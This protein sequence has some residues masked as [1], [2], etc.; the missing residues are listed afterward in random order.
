[1]STSP[2]S[3]LTPDPAFSVPAASSD[4]DIVADGLRKR[5]IA[6]VVVDDGQAARAAVHNL[7]PEGAHVFNATSRTLE[8]I[9]LAK[10]I[11]EAG[12]YQATRDLVDQLNPQTQ[13][14]EYRR[15]VASPQVVVGSVHA[16]TR[17]GQL[18]I[19]SASGSQL[20]AYAFGSTQV[21]WV[22]GAQKVVDDLEHGLQR[23]QRY[24]YPLEDAR[25]RVAYGMPSAVNKQ[26]IISGEYPGRAT[27]VLV[28]EPLG[29]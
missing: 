14:D 12:R 18:I 23:V 22:V 16:V 21:I 27:V 20:A 26:L 8:Q 19:A 1:M 7:I 4:L 24:A 9:G 29:F 10:D 15:A 3:P 13:A 17:D 5:G 25:A 28:R 11:T 6:A 2:E